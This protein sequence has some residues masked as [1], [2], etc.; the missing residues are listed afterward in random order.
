M[1]TTKDDPATEVTTNSN[2]SYERVRDTILTWPVSMRA[3]LMHELL[4]TLTRHEEVPERRRKAL[5]EMPGLLKINKPSAS[6][7]GDQPYGPKRHTVDDALGLARTNGP[8][9]SDEDIESWLDQR[10]MEKYG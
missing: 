4:D 3:I 6:G 5:S 8:A 9:P 2:L 1:S 7:E 10:R